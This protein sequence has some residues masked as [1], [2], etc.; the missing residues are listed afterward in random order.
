MISDGL[1]AIV[2]EL[3]QANLVSGITFGKYRATGP[4]RARVKSVIIN[5]NTLIVKYR[6]Q[7]GVQTAN[8]IVRNVDSALL[9]IDQYR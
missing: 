9:I 7:E 5:N 6:D 3:K 2:N 1:Q 8:I 4:S